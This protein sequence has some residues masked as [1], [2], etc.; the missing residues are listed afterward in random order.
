MAFYSGPRSDASGNMQ[1][2]MYTPKPLVWEDLF[3][4]IYVLLRAV[5]RRD[6]QT[7]MERFNS[8]ALARFSGEK[9]RLKTVVSPWPPWRIP[10][11]CD[12]GFDDPRVLLHSSK[13]IMTFR[14]QPFRFLLTGL[15]N[16]CFFS[17]ITEY[18]HGLIFNLLYRAV[19]G[20]R[21][22]DVITSLAVHLLELAVTYSEPATYGTVS[23]LLGVILFCYLV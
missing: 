21:I 19:Y 8:F 11:P 4:P 22:N 14:C 15:R 2:G 18:I 6:F 20:P 9:E 13:S 12:K 16:V 3:D 17:P 10:A 7:S 23:L 5:H 1:P